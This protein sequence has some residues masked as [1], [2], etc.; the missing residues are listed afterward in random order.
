VDSIGITANEFRVYETLLSSG[1]S[2]ISSIAS[3]A[4]LDQRST[5][6]YI[7]RLIYKGL[8]GQIIHNNK[9]LFLGLNPETLGSIIDD[10]ISEAEAELSAL[11]EIAGKKEPDFQVS[12]IGNRA[13]FE[14]KLREVG[15]NASVFVG[16]GTEEIT[17]SP[18]FRL[19]KKGGLKISKGR[20]KEPLVALFFDDCFILYSVPDEKGFYARDKAFSDS[21]R[22]YF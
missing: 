2:T 11:L 17:E 6:D 13:E 7:E 22:V 1:A 3:A 12:L 9:R 20:M 16:S 10:K 4:K 14:S 18:K 15:R 8:V 21:M 5:Y 19:L